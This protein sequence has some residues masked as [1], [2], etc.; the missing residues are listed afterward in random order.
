M[1]VKTRPARPAWADDP[2]TIDASTPALG[3][4]SQ[5]Q[6]MLREAA[7]GGLAM[8]DTLVIVTG[9]TVSVLLPSYDDLCEWATWLD[10]TAPVPTSTSAQ[11]YSTCADGFGLHVQLVSGGA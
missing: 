11:R 3:E 10:A 2:P 7:Y 4:I 6:T 1:R 8:P 5:V 9:I